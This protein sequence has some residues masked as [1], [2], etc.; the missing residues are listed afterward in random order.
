MLFSRF[1]PE[2]YFITQTIVIRSTRNV[3]EH[4]SDFV[5]QRQQR[6]SERDGAQHTR[7]KS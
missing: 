4:R 2:I 1:T 5:F 3:E 6:M 7:K